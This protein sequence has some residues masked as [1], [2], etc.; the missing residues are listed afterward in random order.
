ML[1]KEEVKNTAKLAR[2]NLTEKE[3]EQ[4]QGDLSLI[5]DYFEKLKKVDVTKATIEANE[6]LA[7]DGARQDKV[8]SLEGEQVKDIRKA[9]PDKEK[10]Y[11][12]VK[13]ILTE[14]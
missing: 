10:N 6:P 3:I 2:V 9:F 14:Q 7:I 1:S 11:L 13:S 5:F 8:E 4:Y 12:K